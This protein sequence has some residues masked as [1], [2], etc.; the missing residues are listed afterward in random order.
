LLT[1]GGA[2]SGLINERGYSCWF[3]SRRGVHEIYESLTFVVG[4]RF[5]FELNFTSALE[6]RL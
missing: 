2:R 3:Q 4:R 1:I 5:K 6:G